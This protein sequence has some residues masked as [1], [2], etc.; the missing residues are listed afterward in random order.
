[1]IRRH[2]G[3]ALTLATTANIALAQVRNIPPGHNILE[4][5]LYHASTVEVLLLALAPKIER[6]LFYAASAPASSRWIDLTKNLLDR[7]VTTGA[8]S[9]TGLYLNAMTAA[10]ALYICFRKSV[11]GVAVNVADANGIASTATW[12]YLDTENAWTSLSATDGT[13]PAGGD[14]VTLGQ[15]GLVTW[16]VPN[17]DLWGARLLPNFDT[18]PPGAIKSL[19]GYWVRMTVSA[20][21]TNPTSIVEII[22]LANINTDTLTARL[23]EP[24]IRLLTHTTAKPPS[25]FNVEGYGGVE[26]TST[27]LTSALNL[28]WYEDR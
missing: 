4:V 10:D 14:V 26:I 12:S 22:S 9:G 7:N 25:R 15:D 20:T 27:T 28:N 13:D 21:L 24:R 2:R 3:E 23:G 5:D 19:R 18:A 6:I 17:A 11:R 8:A 16:T 1:M